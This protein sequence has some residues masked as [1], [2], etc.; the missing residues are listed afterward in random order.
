MIQLLFTNK[1]CI[2][3][4]GKPYK[5]HFIA[6]HINIIFPEY[7]TLHSICK[8]LFSV[9]LSSTAVVSLHSQLIWEGTFLCPHVVN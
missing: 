5:L 1:M 9:E 4:L 3:I 7:F 2:H 6:C 8:I